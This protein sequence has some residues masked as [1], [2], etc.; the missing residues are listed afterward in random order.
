MTKQTSRYIIIIPNIRSVRMDS[1]NGKVMTAM[2]IEEMKKRKIERGLSNK[3]LAEL[4]GV[5]LGTLQRILAGKTK[6]PRRDTVE[7][8]TR[9]LP[10][11]KNTFTP[12]INSVL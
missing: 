1:I 5:P 11:L 7:A 8:L 4:S 10:S 3:Q 6:A 12:S 9:A 2:T